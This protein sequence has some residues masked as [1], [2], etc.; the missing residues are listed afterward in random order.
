VWS[1][2]SIEITDYKGNSIPNTYYIKRNKNNKLAITFPGYGYLAEAPLLFYLNEILF[3]LHFD[4]LSIEYAYKKNTEFKK[5]TDLEQ[6]KWFDFDIGSI[7]KKIVDYKQYDEL[8]LAGKSLGTTALLNMIRLGIPHVRQKY[9]WLTPGTAHTDIIIT[10]SNLNRP[11]LF[12]VGTADSF[13]RK[14]EYDLLKNIPDIKIEVFPNANHSL[15]IDN[16][17]DNSI[18]NIINYINAIRIFIQ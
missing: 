12:I 5:A 10:A 1:D 16:D 18:R 8:V 2:K 15:E 13:F 9:I 4:V 14:E 11:S 7:Y 3:Q 17:I 6:T